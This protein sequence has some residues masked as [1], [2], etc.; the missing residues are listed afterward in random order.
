MNLID[1]GK[2]EDKKM[3]GVKNWI[4]SALQLGR[5][6][7]VSDIYKFVQNEIRLEKT[8]TILRGEFDIVTGPSRTGN[9][10]KLTRRVNKEPTT[11]STINNVIIHRA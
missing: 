5:S 9:E 4:E 8:R 2:D 11:L 6:Y 7:V 3:E 10:L 1:M